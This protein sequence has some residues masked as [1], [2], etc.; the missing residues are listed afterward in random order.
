MWNYAMERSF[1]CHKPLY[2]CTRHDLGI[3]VEINGHRF[4]RY[5][6][7]ETEALAF[8]AYNKATASWQGDWYHDVPMTEAE[9]NAIL[10]KY[11]RI[12]QGMRPISEL[13]G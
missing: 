3:G 5:V 8:V 2:V 13:L 7:F 11:S 4:R 1:P 12:D 9:A 6:G 10:A